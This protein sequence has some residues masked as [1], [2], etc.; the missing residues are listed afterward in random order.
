VRL[1]AAAIWLAAGVAK[2]VDLEQ[3]HAQVQAYDLLPAALEALATALMLLFVVAIAQAWARGLSLDCGC[4]GGA[5]REQVGPL[6]L[7]RNAGLGL[8]SLLLLLRPARRLSL[9]TRLRALPDRFDRSLRRCPAKSRAR[10]V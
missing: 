4:F 5:A 7:V 3:F 2:V 1:A 8:P 9:D 6:A 10:M